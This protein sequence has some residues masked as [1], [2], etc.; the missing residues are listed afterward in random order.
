MM[1]A[2][3]MAAG[4]W[5]VYMG[6]EA[7]KHREHMILTRWGPDISIG[8]GIALMAYSALSSSFGSN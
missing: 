5:C 4:A 3:G 2:I 8:M 6:I 7:C 1:R